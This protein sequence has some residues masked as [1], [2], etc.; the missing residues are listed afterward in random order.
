MRKYVFALLLAASIWGI[1]D[2]QFNQIMGQLIGTTSGS[3]S[4]QSVGGYCWYLGAVAASCTTTCSTR[5]GYNAGTQ[6]Y[7][8]NTGSNANCAAVLTALSRPG[9]VSDEPSTGAWDTSGCG[10]YMG[11]MSMRFI[12]GATST[13]ASYAS[14]ERACACNN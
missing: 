7:A 3:C 5:G 4:G 2:G 8:G 9:A 10:S 1:A 11:S 13:G 14:F 12:G 6:S